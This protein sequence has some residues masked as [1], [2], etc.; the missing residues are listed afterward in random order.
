MDESSPFRRKWLYIVAW[1]AILLIIYGW[2]IALMGG[3]E[4]SIPYLLLDLACFFPILLVLWMA[5]F[6]QFV[7]PVHTFRDRQKIFDRLLL[8]LFGR[9]GPALFIENGEIKEHSGERLKKGP[10]VVWLDSASAAVTRTATK[11]KQTIGPGVHFIERGEFIAG[12]VDF[13]IQSQRIGPF[14]NQKEQKALFLDK[15]PESKKEEENKEDELTEEEFNNI[16]DR[17][18]QVSALTR[19]G[20]EVIP[21]ISITFRAN[22]GFPKEGQPDSRFGYRT[23]IT[24]KDRENED[25]DKDAICR[26]IL[27]EGI[28]PNVLRDSPRHRVKWN[29]LPAA[30]A[31]DVWREYVAKFTLDELFKPEQLVPPPPPKP[32]EPTEEEIDPLSQPVQVGASRNRLEAGIAAII[33][34]INLIMSGAIKSLEGEKK[35]DKSTKPA[36]PAPFFPDANEKKGPQKKTA[37]Q[38]VNEMMKARLTQPEVDIMNDTGQRG[39]GK[40]ASQEYRLLEE[41]GLKVLNVSISDV[42]LNPTVEEQV[43]KQWTATWLTNAKAESE[44]IDRKRNII[45]TSAQEQALV[46]YAEI[47]SRKVNDLARNGKSD[48]KE[49][50]KTLLM[51]SRALIRSGEHSEQLRRRMSTELQE[52]ED[53]IKWVEVNGK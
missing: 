11:I 47:I 46:K 24:K 33:H 19:D 28:N 38:V 18:K 9:H 15:K 13:H 6:S 26:A 37:L 34:E 23:G 2:Q 35:G 7:L 12:T 50:L 27:G 39:Q 43:I 51:R 4:A 3:I 17:R 48:I 22:T 36:A 14:E 8:D 20:I 41:R 16:Q 1:L 10:G 31:V 30:L 32:P 40:I 45:E 29:E 25:K 21:N 53:M 44:Q 52:I 5:F 42:R 49:T